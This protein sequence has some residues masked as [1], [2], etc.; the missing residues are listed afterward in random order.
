MQGTQFG[1]GFVAAVPVNG[2]ALVPFGLLKDVSVDIAVKHTKERGQWQHVV[3][4]GRGE[5]EVTGKIGSVSLLSGAIGQILGGTPATGSVIG[6]PHECATI[7]ATPFSVTVVNSANFAADYGVIDLTTGK[8]LTKTASTVS[9]GLYSVTSG[10]YTFAEA[11][12]G[13]RVAIAYTYTAASSGKTTPIFNATMQLANGFVLVAY[14]AGAAGN[15]F[16]VKF[17]NAYFEK[18]GFALKATDFTTQGV[19]FFAAMDAGG[20]V[21]EIYTGE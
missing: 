3:A 11:D 14:G 10:V 18:L 15:V 19:E 13:H 5:V 21:M 4:V 16:G 9:T 8:M 20:D 6:V 12:T 1:L 7:P 17:S 2:T